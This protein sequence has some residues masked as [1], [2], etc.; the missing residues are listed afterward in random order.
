MAIN[1]NKR[2]SIIKYCSNCS[3]ELT[4]FNW[5]DGDQKRNNYLCKK[6]HKERVDKCPSQSKESMKKYRE[7]H[8]NHIRDYHRQR[9]IK[10]RDENGKQILIRANKRLYPKNDI[11]EICGKQVVKLDYH[12]W[13]KNNPDNGIWCCVVCHRGCDSMEKNPNLPEIYNNLKLKI[14]RK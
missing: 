10:S 2:E 11:C 12:H 13:D 7:K 3:I 14:E 6:C 1:I 5:S 8:R 9:W 4:V